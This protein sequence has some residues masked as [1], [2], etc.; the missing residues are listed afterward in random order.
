MDFPRTVDEITP[1]WL[2]QVLRESGA[3]TGSGVESF[4]SI[5]IGADQGLQG[6]VSRLALTYQK[7]DPQG[8]E[9][10]IVKLSLADDERRAGVNLRGFSEREAVLYSELSATAGIAVPKVHFASFDSE[11][12]LQQEK[13]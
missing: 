8:P 4:S 9:S 3:I 10:V 11:S 5:E 1:E 12:G 7:S 6:E 2:T 13:I